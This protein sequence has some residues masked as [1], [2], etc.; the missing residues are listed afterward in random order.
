[1]QVTL[2]RGQGIDQKIELDKALKRLKGKIDAEG[3]MDV[4]RAKRAFETPKEKRER[5]QRL[6]AK[7]AKLARA[8]NNKHK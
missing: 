5:K 8:N 3:I 2:K 7:K 6:V 1:M 4:L